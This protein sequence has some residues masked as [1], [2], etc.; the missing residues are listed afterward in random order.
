M[1][2]ETLVFWLNAEQHRNDAHRLMSLTKRIHS[3]HIPSNAPLALNITSTERTGIERAI[4]S[5]VTCDN[6]FKV[7]KDAAF[8]NLYTDAWPRFLQWRLELLHSKLRHGG[9]TPVGS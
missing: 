9:L 3:L 7:A 4:Q 6:P 2:A 8:Q 1:N 5:F